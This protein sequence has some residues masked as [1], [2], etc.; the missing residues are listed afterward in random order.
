[1]TLDDSRAER[2]ARVRKRITAA[3]ID[4]LAI[5]VVSGAAWW[6]LRADLSASV[7]VVALAYYSI[8]TATLGHG[9]GSRLLEDRSWRRPEKPALPAE[10]SLQ[11][12]LLERMREVKG[13][14]RA[15]RAR[16]G[17]RHPGHAHRHDHPHAICALSSP[18]APRTRSYL[19]SLAAGSAIVLKYSIA[20]DGTQSCSSSS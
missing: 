20:S 15:A 8:S 6:G 17:G 5:L 14:P 1:M 12:T 16:D 9:L 18:P 7:A 10:P 4:I 3:A 11:D 19:F 13:L 2:I